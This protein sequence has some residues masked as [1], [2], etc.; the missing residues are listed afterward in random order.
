[1]NRSSTTA[2]KHPKTEVVRL[3]IH[4]EDDLSIAIRIVVGEFA[5]RARDT[6]HP[7]QVG[8]LG[9]ILAMQI[10]SGC[11][12]VIEVLD[13]TAT[14]TRRVTLRRTRF[15]L[16]RPPD[17]RV[18]LNIAAEHFVEVWG[19]RASVLTKA[20]VDHRPR[21]L[22]TLR[23]SCDGEF[24]EIIAKLDHQPGTVSLVSQCTEDGQ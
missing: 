17:V 2:A 13:E 15:V 24:N 7:H 23:F 10:M 22:T 4:D 20:S 18:P 12:A 21:L 5:K 1:M 14:A 19:E 11:S 9:A 16:L 8:C 6:L 3:G